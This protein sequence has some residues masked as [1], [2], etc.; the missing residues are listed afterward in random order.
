MCRAG[1]APVRSGSP[2]AARDGFPL[3]G[4]SIEMSVK[5]DC[6]VVGEI[7]YREGD[8]VMMQVPVGPCQV[9]LTDADATLSWADGDTHGAA[10][11]PLS[12]YARYVKTGAL[13]Q[14]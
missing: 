12:D 1:G 4:G 2:V 13:K 9:E 10:T 11:I 3:P 7:A 14:V 6:E 5:R 8:G